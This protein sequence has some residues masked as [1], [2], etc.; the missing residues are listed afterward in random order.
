MLTP[1]LLSYRFALNSVPEIL[2]N[3]IQ[4]LVSL[5]RIEKYLHTPEVSLKPSAIAAAPE[6]QETPA[7]V[8][9]TV[10]WPRKNGDDDS[11]P[12]SAAPSGTST[13][14]PRGFELQD[15][16]VRFPVGKLSLI[17]GS[18][19]SGKT[20][21]LLALLGEADVLAGDV[22]CPRSP[23]DAITLPNIDWDRLL[24]ADNWIQPNL[25]AFVPQSAW[26]QNASIRAN[27]C[28]GLPFRVDRYQATL[29]ACSLVSDLAILEDGDETEIGEKVRLL[30]LLTSVFAR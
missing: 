15:I 19:G 14:A 5:R 9:A 21:M 30:A 13:P 26:L 16:D 12:N 1:P 7:F 18:L 3:A 27:I 22:V 17:C 29:E 11:S 28:F 25:T 8:S 23:P 2:V 24:T 4:C 6:A 10:T 20:L